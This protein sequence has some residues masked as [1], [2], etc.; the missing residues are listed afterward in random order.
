MHIYICV[1]IICIIYI[2]V[3]ISEPLGDFFFSGLE[4]ASKFMHAI[5]FPSLGSQNHRSHQIFG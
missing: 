5:E 3:Q 1:S 2:G 4:V